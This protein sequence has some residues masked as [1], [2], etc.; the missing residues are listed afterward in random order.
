MVTQRIWILPSCIWSLIITELL[1]IFL[2]HSTSKWKRMNS[3]LVRWYQMIFS[4]KFLGQKN[5]CFHAFVFV[6]FLWVCYQWCDNFKT[7]PD[8]FSSYIFIFTRENRF[9]ETRNNFQQSLHQRSI[10]CLLLS[11]LG[12]LLAYSSTLGLIFPYM[13]LV[14]V[15]WWW[16]RLTPSYSRHTPSKVLI[17]TKTVF[18][19]QISVNRLRDLM[20]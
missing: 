7:C 9:H 15:L 8:Q 5:F 11:I 12:K 19:L 17:S 1:Q 2:N 13:I 20:R 10:W 3:S 6:I 14:L 16:W 18:S 4:N